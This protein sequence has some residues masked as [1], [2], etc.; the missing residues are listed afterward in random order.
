MTA[1]LT[2]TTTQTVWVVRIGVRG[3]LDDDDSIVAAT[4]LDRVAAE[5]HATWL[6]DEGNTRVWVDETTPADPVL[7]AVAADPWTNSTDPTDE[8]F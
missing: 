5:D 1:T 6:R 3:A 4:H 7:A 8:P 2:E